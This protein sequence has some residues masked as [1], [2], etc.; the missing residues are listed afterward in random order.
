MKNSSIKALLTREIVFMIKNSKH[1]YVY[2]AIFYIFLSLITMG[3][4]DCFN[5]E[6]INIFFEIFNGVK[7]S[8]D[9]SEIQFPAIWFL[10][11]FIIVYVIGKQGYEDFSKNGIYVITRC[12]KSKFWLCK[13]I[14]SIINV[15]V[16]YCIV[17][18]IPYIIGRIVVGSC[19]KVQFDIISLYIVTT[20]MLVAISSVVSL[21]VDYKYSLLIVTVLLI[22]S[23]Y[24]ESNFMPGQHSIILRHTPYDVE[25][26]LSLAKSMIYTSVVFI[27]ALGVGIK[28]S[29]KKEII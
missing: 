13:L 3:R 18:F 16:Y 19:V 17:F 7:Y 5:G 9:I 25:H 29:S 10:T 1:T 24:I 21:V 22:A 12:G 28:L 26:N 23:V 4:F 15:V 8:K 14:A 6:G 20:I 2:I 27:V 11:N